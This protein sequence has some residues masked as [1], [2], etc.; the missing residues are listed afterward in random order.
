MLNLSLLELLQSILIIVVSLTIHEFAHAL[1]AISLG[2]TTPLEDGRLTLNPLKHIDLV[3]FIMLVV[4]G[5]G[6]AKP[7]RIDAARL[8][9]P[10]RDE[11]LISIAGP[12][13]NGLF[14]LFLAVAL[15]IIMVVF[16]IRSPARFNS[17][18]NFITQAAMINIALALFNLLPIP[19]LDGSHL[20]STF[21]AKV[22]TTLA[23]TY[24]RYGSFA[25][26]ALIIVERVTRI[27]IL[28]IGRVTRAIVIWMYQGLG[29]LA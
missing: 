7:V 6:W 11:I 23:G 24:F 28:P 21:L 12:F 10:R 15:K 27:D 18:A 17:I 25:L 26:L 2:D 29:V 20:I 22:N 13:S 5:F 9:K 1:V 19:P 3:G 16:V 14:A 8:K 4:A